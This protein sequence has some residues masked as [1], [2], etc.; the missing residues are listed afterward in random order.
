MP[1][2]QSEMLWG[3]IR[4]PT[5]FPATGS[6]W[7]RGPLEI[8]GGARRERRRCWAGKCSLNQNRCC[9]RRADGA[10]WPG[11]NGVFGCYPGLSR[12]FFLEVP[13]RKLAGHPATVR[14]DASLKDMAFLELQHAHACNDRRNSHQHSQVRKDIN[15]GRA[16]PENLKKSIHRPVNECQ[17]AECLNEARHE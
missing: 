11:A 10:S 5:S 16:S 1:H 7:N 13:G 6:S 14:Y 2:A 3:K 12:F 17:F 4:S 8:T 15:Y 9:A